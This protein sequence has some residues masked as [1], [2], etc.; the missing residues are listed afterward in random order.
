[1]AN[2]TEDLVNGYYNYEKLFD[3]IMK[4][5]DQFYYQYIENFD[6]KSHLSFNRNNNDKRN[7][8]PKSPIL[9]KPQLKKKKINL[10]IIKEKTVWI[11][12]LIISMI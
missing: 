4:L 2:L 7:N 9:I 5:V 11:I 3:G 12:S 1:M 8:E 6:K 10:L